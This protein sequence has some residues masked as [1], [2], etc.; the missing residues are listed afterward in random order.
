MTGAVAS[1][2]SSAS[3]ASAAERTAGDSSVANRCRSACEEAASRASPS[4]AAA[5]LRDPGA[6]A[7]ASTSRN[8]ASAASVPSHRV[9]RGGAGDFAG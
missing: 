1:S 6:V 3:A 5:W 7:W 9:L 8:A 4:A 2:L